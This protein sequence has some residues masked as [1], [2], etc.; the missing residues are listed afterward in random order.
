MIDPN[1]DWSI[2][3]DMK[4]VPVYPQEIKAIPVY[5]PIPRPEDLGG[6]WH[7]T[8]AYLKRVWPWST[9]WLGFVVT[10]H[11]PQAAAMGATI[12]IAVDALNNGRKES[13][14]PKPFEPLEFPIDEALTKRIMSMCGVKSGTVHICDRGSGAHL[15]FAFAKEGHILISERAIKTLSQA[16]V[17]FILAR[18]ALNLRPRQSFGVK[19]AIAAT[20]FVGAAGLG[21]VF[22]YLHAKGFAGLTVL[23]LVVLFFFLLGWSYHFYHQAREEARDSSALSLTKNVDAALSSIEMLPI[24]APPGTSQ[25]KSKRL[26]A[27][28]K[29]RQAKLIAYAKERLGISPSV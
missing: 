4:T 15:M 17:D 19:L 21:M 10:A 7:S 11:D 22:S 13:A 1:K 25:V 12:H 28:T 8:L 26:M 24:L 16:Q 2:P 14:N 5:P 23:G 29:K 20:S 27:W 18:L 3:P 6:I 9:L